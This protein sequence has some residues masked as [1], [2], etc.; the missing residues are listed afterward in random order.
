MKNNFQSE[1]LNEVV[2]FVLFWFLFT[3]INENEY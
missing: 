2:N 1:F 3:K